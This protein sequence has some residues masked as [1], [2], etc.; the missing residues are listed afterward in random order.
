MH[1][2]NMDLLVI[3]AKAGDPD[4]FTELIQVHMKDLKTGM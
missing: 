4:A 3:N 1:K 2:I